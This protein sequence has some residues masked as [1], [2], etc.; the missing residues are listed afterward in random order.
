MASMK[1]SKITQLAMLPFS[2]IGVMGIA[3]H[4]FP[5]WM[6]LNLSLSTS[7]IMVA[8]AFGVTFLVSYLEASRTKDK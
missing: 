3:S 6:E 2:V 1:L 7:L 5:E 8:G 4:F